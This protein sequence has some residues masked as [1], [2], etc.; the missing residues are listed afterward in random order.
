MER[1]P[2]PAD[3][4]SAVQRIPALDGLRGI[5]ILLVVLIHTA[6][7][8]FPSGRYGVTMFFVLSGFLIT[9][10]LLSDGIDLK[11]FYK[12]RAARLLPALFVVSAAALAIGISWSHV[13]PALAYVANYRLIGGDHMGNMSH[14]WSLAVEEHFY[15]IWPWLLIVT[16]HQKRVRWLAWAMVG[17]VL[18]RGWLILGESSWDRVQLATDASAVALGAG[19]LLAAI[20]HERTLLKIRGG[21]IA[22]GLIVGLAVVIPF[23]TESYLWFDFAVVALSVV[24][25]HAATFGSR[26]LEWGPLRGLGVVSYGLYLWHNL[27]VWIDWDVGIPSPIFA[28]VLSL[29]LTLLSWRV[30][31]QP[32]IA[33]ARRGRSSGDERPTLIEAVGQ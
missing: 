9:T 11:R 10:I 4:V 22:V 32:C 24:A 13:W 3:I 5:A 33:W 15:L 2:G 1:P 27:F 8:W 7:G 16:P 29:T 17:A 19:C 12:R 23:K 18:W 30:I 21:L 26:L 14:T 6:R 25:I 28:I 31:E 20:R